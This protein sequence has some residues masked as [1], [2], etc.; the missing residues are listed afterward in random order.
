MDSMIFMGPFQL[1]IFYDSIICRLTLRVLWAR[2]Q[3]A[4]SA[5]GA[6]RAGMAQAMTGSLP[7]LV[8]P[9]AASRRAALSH[10]CAA[11][12]YIFVLPSLLSEINS[13]P[14]N[15]GEGLEEISICGRARKGSICDTEMLFCK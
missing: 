6:G 8:L 1:G 11:L 9:S 14:P 7:F 12:I 4:V 13:I 10:L 15:N 5:V 3:W 2:N